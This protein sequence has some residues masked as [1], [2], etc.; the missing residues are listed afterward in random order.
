MLFLLFSDVVFQHFEEKDLTVSHPELKWYGPRFHLNVLLEPVKDD[1]LEEHPSK[2]LL[3]A[4]FS[5]MDVA[6]FH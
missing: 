3:E 4:V 1:F 2:F 5:P 6:L